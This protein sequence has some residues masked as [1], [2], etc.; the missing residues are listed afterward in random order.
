LP[1]GPPRRGSV[2]GR[3]R[4]PAKRGLGRGREPAARAEGPDGIP[5]ARQDRNLRTKREKGVR[6]LFPVTCHPSVR[7]RYLTP[8]SLFLGVVAQERHAA[9]RAEEAGLGID[10][11]LVARVGDVEIAH[12]ELPDAVGRTEERL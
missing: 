1:P 9:A 11:Q 7:K 8:F 5:A 3:P 4:G 2:R 6:Y 12:R 10:A